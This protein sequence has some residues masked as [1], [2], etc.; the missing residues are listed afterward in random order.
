MD[1]QDRAGS[2][3]N[4]SGTG[5]EID[6]PVTQR[7]SRSVHEWTYFIRDAE[8]IKIGRSIYPL[9]RMK[10]FQAGNGSKMELLI[11]VP[12][13]ELSEPQAHWKF[14]HLRTHGEWFR[15]EQ[16]LLDFIVAMKRQKPKRAARGNPIVGK[17]DALRRAH[18]FNTP[19]GHSCSNLMEMIP[20]L[21]DYVRPAWATHPT[22]T[23]PWMIERQ[24]KRMEAARA[25]L[26]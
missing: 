13:S 20:L 25:A 16:D 11:A 15:P 3:M 9:G 18:G 5:R 12:S 10:N 22:Q 21:A 26:N 6:P 4:D 14:Q 19:I 8:G 17:L 2:G 7:R 24:M 1:T 23:L